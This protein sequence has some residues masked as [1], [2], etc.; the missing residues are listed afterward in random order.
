MI[1]LIIR[2][3]E[4]EL[5]N[6]GFLINEKTNTFTA[7]IITVNGILTAEQQKCIGEAATLFGNGIIKLS[8]SFT[9][10]VKGIPYEKINDFR[11]YMGKAGLETY[12]YFI[13]V[14]TFFYN[15]K[16]TFFYTTS[17]VIA[18]IFISL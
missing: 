10:E 18:V 15:I 6:M 5:K 3:D 8:T 9:I 13:S 11:E 14:C 16:M 4:K 1:N 7:N 2:Q 12:K 17:T